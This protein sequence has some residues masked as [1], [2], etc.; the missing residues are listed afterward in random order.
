MN[1]LRILAWKN[2]KRNKKR[3]IA[4]IIGIV[5]SVALISFILTLIYSFKYSML[6]TTKRN[7]GNY[8]I[9]IDQTTT[10]KAI[11]FAKM[12]DKIERI[13]ISQ[14]IG[15]ANYESQ[16]NTKNGIIIDGY[17]EVSLTNRDI[18]LIE[19]RLPQNEK[20]ILVSNYLI[21]NLDEPI[22]IGD[23]LTLDVE[24]VK[25]IISNDGMQESLEPDGIERV[26]YTVT[27]I[28]QQTRKEANTSNA[29]IATTKLEQ[30][31]EVRPC[32]V[33]MLLKNPKEENLFY[34]ELNNSSMQNHLSENN[35]L[36]IWQGATKGMNEK[37]QLELIGVIAIII[38][39][40]ITIVLVRNSFQIS[41]SERMKEFGTLISIGATSKQIRK[42]VLIEGLIYAII[43][44]PIGLIF[45][46]GVV[47]FSIN[48]IEKVLASTFGNSWIMEFSINIPFIFV[49]ILITILAIL[50]SCIKPIRKAKKASPIE[51]I[52]QN[53][54][55]AIKN[56][57]VKVSK[58]K[59]KLLGI[60]GQ[61][62]YKNI[63]RNKN[64]YRSTTISISIIMILV[65]LISSIIQY[66]FL[67]VNNTYKPTNRNIDVGMIYGGGQEE[68]DTVFKNFDRIKEMDSII[69][70]SIIVR[71]NGIMKNNNKSISIHAYEGNTYEDYLKSMG[72]KYED[73]FNN[74]I[75]LSANPSVKE[76][77]I[78][79]IIINEKEYKIPIIKTTNLD[80]E[81]AIFDLDNSKI[82]KIDSDSLEYER[83]II[84]N[85]MA[86]K[87][88][89]NDEIVKGRFSM[90]MRVN[91]SNP[92]KL[93]KEIEQ[94]VNLDK[95]AI[96]NYTKQKE[97]EEKLSAMMSIF[98]YG[99]L[100][101]ISLIGI[102]NIYNTITASMNLRKREFEILKAIGMSNKQFNKMFVYESLIYG[103]KSLIIGIILGTILSYALYCIINTDLALK[104]YFPAVQMIIM[105]VLTILV[106]YMSNKIAWKNHKIR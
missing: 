28:I 10:Q 53:N 59:V 63:K 79:N 49:T 27:G 33:T 86:K 16:L 21:N 18:N 12:T 92:N 20:E 87:I 8:H 39:V 11:E 15:A 5:V 19:G 82:E 74:G 64:Q 57:D 83:L 97:D 32:E 31:T 44:I 17:D 40:A 89:I 71:F 3:T 99:L 52:K 67:I 35:E 105:A 51:T 70:Y 81:V 55:I 36:L 66:I 94:F 14:T 102:T 98:L 30:M 103:V 60:E 6:E 75:L 37:S 90:D 88:D 104:Y 68:T 23:Q 84:S 13:G 48:G 91:S 93:E 1:I 77:E 80:P 100:L 42:I 61:I 72:L 34:Q 45:G 56:K 29:Y 7:V 24:K 78:L 101:V 50:F 38:V 95:I 2:L 58:L 4:T 22:K 85:D 73:T 41:I 69:D 43:S 46:I 25:L 47:Y 9:H 26:T 96:T 76:G 62:A 65:I 54:E 106:I